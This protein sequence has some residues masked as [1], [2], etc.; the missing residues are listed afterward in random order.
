MPA[1]YEIR[2]GGDPVQMKNKKQSMAE[3]KLRRLM[4]LNARLREDLE[5]RRIPVSEAAMEYV[6]PFYC[7]SRRPCLKLLSPSVVFPPL[8]QSFLHVSALTDQLFVAA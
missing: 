4:E 8:H 6:T 2:A 7:P 3:L 5:R 1:G